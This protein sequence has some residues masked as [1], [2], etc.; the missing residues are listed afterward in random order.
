VAINK[1]NYVYWGD[2]LSPKARFLFLRLISPPYLPKKINHSN[3]QLVVEL[4]RQI[5]PEYPLSRAEKKVV[6]KPKIADLLPEVV[7]K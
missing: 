4:S 5:L 7:L 1:R 3:H 2:R 6:L